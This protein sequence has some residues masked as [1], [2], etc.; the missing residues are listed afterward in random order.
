MVRVWLHCLRV[1]TNDG[2]S[3]GQ[4]VG[5]ATPWDV[6]APRKVFSDLCFLKE[7]THGRFRFPWCFA[8]IDD[9]GLYASLKSS[10]S[11]SLSTAQAM[12]QDS[13]N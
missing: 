3:T 6:M 1:I 7:A 11:W 13:M 5:I 10:K 8:R 12:Q 9:R 2:K 4:P